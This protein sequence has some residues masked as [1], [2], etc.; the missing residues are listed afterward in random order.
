MAGIK[1]DNTRQENPGERKPGPI[2]SLGL[3]FDR[4][5]KHHE[6]RTTQTAALARQ[7]S[8]G[9]TSPLQMPAD[10]ASRRRLRTASYGSQREPGG[11]R[12]KIMMA[13]IPVLAIA[14]LYLLRN[15]LTVSTPATA[16][17]KLPAEVIPVTIPNVEIAWEIPPLYQPGGRDPMRLPAPPVVTVE[18]PVA[19]P[20]Q[21][22][23]DLIVTGILYSE[24]KPAA[25][26]DTFLV[27]EGEQISGATV[28]KI[29]KDGVE[30][31]MNGR[32]WKQAVEVDKK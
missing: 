24:D 17:D 29:E 16:Q 31:E 25:I 13:L 6:A 28:K 2:V 5:A 32:T 10:G 19:A 14:L 23:M 15:P 18:E 12:Q 8:R 26:V 4:R 21:P 1:A 7:G 22:H 11:G 3:H 30:F 20:T 9:R 27:H